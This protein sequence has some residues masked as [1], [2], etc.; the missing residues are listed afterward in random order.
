MNS[1]KI[2]VEGTGTFLFH[3]PLR[4]GL[5]VHTEL[6]ITLFVSSN[7]CCGIVVNDPECDSKELLPSLNRLVEKF[8]ATHPGAPIQVKLFGGGSHMHGQL[9]SIRT[10][11]QENGLHIVAEDL[12]RNTNRNLLVDC[13]S[14]RVGVTYTDRGHR[15][16]H[17]FLS[18]GT[19]KTRI[20]SAP[21]RIRTLVLSN[22]RVNRLLA[23]QAIEEY[24]HCFAT[25]NVKPLQFMKEFPT[26]TFPWNIVI[27]FDDIGW[28]SVTES[29]IRNVSGMNADLRFCW[30]GKQAPLLEYV[31][32][33]YLISP[34][35]PEQI[36]EFKR[37]IRR[38]L[39]LPHHR[40]S[41]QSEV[42]PFRKLKRH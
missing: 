40:T 32:E 30:V 12:G 27:L 10:W 26:R 42:L 4:V 21:T 14:G 20:A 13:G 8:A 16:S 39:D 24:P 41:H 28:N 22:N 38:I 2:N 17:L 7:R 6:V 11:I 34:P 15:D 18:Q 31:G 9:D 3:A 35:N 25:L 37:E 19:A 36:A 23:R 29:W 33:L 1:G 5:K